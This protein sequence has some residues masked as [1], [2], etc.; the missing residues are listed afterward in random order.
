MRKCSYK[1]S[2]EEMN[3]T[4]FH[5]EVHEENEKWKGNLKVITTLKNVNK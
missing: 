2:S 1:F 5:E 4:L 3:D